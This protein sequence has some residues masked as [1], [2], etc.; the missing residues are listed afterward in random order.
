[1]QAELPVV[2]AVSAVSVG[3]RALLWLCCALC[4]LQQCWQGNALPQEMQEQRQQGR[5]RA[6]C[7]D[8]ISIKS[9]AGSVPFS[10]LLLQKAAFEVQKIGGADKNQWFNFLFML[11]PRADLLIHF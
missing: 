4:C 2:R 11:L 10:H 6:S 1:M 7:T 9:T 3:L 8:P 5:E